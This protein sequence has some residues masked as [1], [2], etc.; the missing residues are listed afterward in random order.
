M[1]KEVKEEIH[2]VLILLKGF[3]TKNEVSMAFDKKTEELLFFDTE[4]YVRDNRFDG[5]K[6]KMEELVK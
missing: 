1:T 4:R 2:A 6:V 5:F 3:L